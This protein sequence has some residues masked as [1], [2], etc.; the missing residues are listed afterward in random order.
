[1]QTYFNELADHVTAQLKGDEVATLSFAG[2]DSDF[3]RF[4][5]SEVRQAGS[6]QQRELEIDLVQGAR[7]CSASLT[8]AGDLE[9]DRPRVDK[10]VQGLRETCA[11]LPEDP[12]HLYAT[13]VRSSEHAKQGNLPDGGAA[14]DQVRA[15]GGGRDLVG[16]YA[17]GG[18]HTGFA[19]SLGQRNWHSSQNFNLDWSFYHQADKA[20]KTS[21]A[22]FDWDEAAFGKKVERAGQQLAALKTEARS[23]EKGA[24]R[25]YLTPAALYE[26]MGMLSWGGFGL[27]S[28][29][30]KQTP[31]LKMVESDARMAPSITIREHT[32][33]GVAPN[34]QEQGFLR[35]DGV[36]L[37]EGGEYRDCLVSPR[38]AKEYGV[39]TNGASAWETP[40]SI[41][42]GAGDLPE[43]EVLK[44]LGT[45]VYVSNLWYLN[46]SDMVSCRTTGMTRFATFWVE[47]GEIKAPLNVMRFDE[48]A[49]RVLGKNLVGLTREREMILDAGSYSRR[50]TS[51]GH[52]PGA[53]V[54]D[55]TFTL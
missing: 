3:V 11:F 40:E 52:L 30:T 48:T 32:A 33:G 13:D 10:M 21:Y 55:F 38:S 7:H 4:N 1:M 8:L 15:A 45:G 25:V 18:I 51:S 16:I 2:E 19:N 46:W 37:I 44:R 31:L 53:L 42:L 47:D 6:V 5:Q 28:H 35:P 22:G 9:Q 12:H 39:E 26:I 17:A 34:F 24:Y 41:E 29:R 27:K 23:V 14:V 43:D 36:T 50:S 49:Y 20:V 54:N